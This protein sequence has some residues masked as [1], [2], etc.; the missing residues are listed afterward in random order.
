MTLLL[1]IQVTIQARLAK[2]SSQPDEI[3]GRLDN[4]SPVKV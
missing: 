1:D 3:E 2:N 4:L